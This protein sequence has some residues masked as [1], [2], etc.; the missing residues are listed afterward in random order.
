MDTGAEHEKNTTFVMI[1]NF[2]NSLKKKNWSRADN[3]LSFTVNLIAIKMLYH[4]LKGYSKKYLT[5][6]MTY[7]GD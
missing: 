6:D 4:W 7:A 1:S 5:E 3:L 2:I